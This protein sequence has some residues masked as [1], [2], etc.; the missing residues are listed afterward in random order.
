MKETTKQIGDRGEQL[1]CERLISEGFQIV[2]RNWRAG[3][4]ELDIVAF[5]DQLLHIIEV[6]TRKLGSW[7]T[8]EDAMTRSKVN[9]LIKGAKFFLAHNQ[10]DYE[11][12]FDLMAVDVVSE[13]EYNLRY[14][15]RVIE[16]RW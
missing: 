8:P 14:I 6:K 9:A 7:T 1:A 11:V 2:A 3:S 10:F 4:Y 15:P 16:P 12:Q 13:G 5:K